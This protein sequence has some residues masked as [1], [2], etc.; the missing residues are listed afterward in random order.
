[1]A[2]LYDP[3]N[4]RFTAMSSMALPRFKLPMEAVHL[5]SGQLLIAGGNKISEIFNPASLKFESV[6]GQLSDDWYFMT[7]T[8]LNDG[9]VLL[10]WGS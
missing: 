1:M 5:A 4:G 3:Q 7:E 9:T 10:T 8:R 2:E 6:A